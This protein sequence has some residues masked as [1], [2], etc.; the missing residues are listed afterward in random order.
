MEVE[1]ANVLLAP[2]DDFA[3]SGTVDSSTMRVVA[4]Y[5]TDECG[6]LASYTITWLFTTPGV[7]GDWI[8]EV[9]GDEAPFTVD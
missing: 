9:E 7:A 3:V 2:C 5:P 6:E 1:H 8:L 4:D